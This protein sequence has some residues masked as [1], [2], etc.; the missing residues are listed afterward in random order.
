MGVMS[1]GRRRN[2]RIWVVLHCEVVLTL[3]GPLVDEAV[4]FTASS[5]KSAERLMKKSWVEPGTWWLLESARLDSIEG[6]SEPPVLYSRAGRIIRTRPFEK[7]TRAALE[8]DK[9]SVE[10]IQKRLKT[11]RESGLSK[12]VI[13][14]LRTS[15]RSIRKVL[16]Q[17]HSR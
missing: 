6:T 8:R 11:A 5:R 9:R 12:Q 14:N 13:K 1:R 3:Q 16:A 2:P 10:S 4:F 7:G 15:V 17:C